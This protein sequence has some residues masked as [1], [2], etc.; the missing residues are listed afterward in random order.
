MVKFGDATYS[1]GYCDRQGTNINGKK[2]KKMFVCNIIVGETCV[3]NGSMT[4]PPTKNDGKQYDTLVNS[5]TNPSIYVICKDYHA[6]PKYLITFRQ[7]G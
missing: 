2:H 5:I 6:I 1:H 3:G 4:V 7:K